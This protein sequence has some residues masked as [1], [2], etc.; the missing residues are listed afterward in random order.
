MEIYTGGQDSTLI[1]WKLSYKYSLTIP[2][3]SEK[4]LSA[5][6][7]HMVQWVQGSLHELLNLPSS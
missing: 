6:L 3:L 7:E 1:S 4:I 5:P 2:Y